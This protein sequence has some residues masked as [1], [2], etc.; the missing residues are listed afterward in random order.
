ML[1]KKET[2][3]LANQYSSADS[4]AKSTT[5]KNKWFAI[6]LAQTL[7]FIVM[8]F[9]L[10]NTADKASKPPQMGWVL[11]YPDGSWRVEFN[12]PSSVQEYFQTTI[13]SLLTKY[14]EYRYQQIPQTIRDDYGRATLFQAAE[15]KENFTSSKGFNAVEKAGVIS[16]SRSPE[17]KRVEVVFFDHQDSVKGIFN[18]GKSNGR[19]VRTTVYVDETITDV[20]GVAI[21]KPVRKIINLSWTLKNPDQLKNKEQKFFSVN[22]LGLEIRTERDT[23]DGAYSASN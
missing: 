6:A 12:A 17:T 22:P 8:L 23:I 9:V 21:G 7:V 4:I 18:G 5:E 2:K 11:L 14:V 13:D 20:N 1:S 3:D 15:V 16:T 19:I 10:N